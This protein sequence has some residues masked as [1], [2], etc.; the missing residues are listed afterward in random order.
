MKP[1][2]GIRSLYDQWSAGLTPAERKHPSFYAFKSWL[3]AKGYSH[4]LK[5]RSRFDQE[6]KQMWRR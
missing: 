6:F 4:Y 2:K 3:E 5:L 1:R